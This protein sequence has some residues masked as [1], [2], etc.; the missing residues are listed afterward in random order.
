MGFLLDRINQK[1]EITNLQDFD[2]DSSFFKPFAILQEEQ[3]DKFVRGL[4][5]E[6]DSLYDQVY[7][8]T[9]EKSL[10]KNIKGSNMYKAKKGFEGYT[11]L[12]AFEALL[13][14]MFGWGNKRPCDFLDYGQGEFFDEN[15]FTVRYFKEKPLYERMHSRGKDGKYFREAGIAQI[16]YQSPIGNFIIKQNQVN[17]KIFEVY[18]SEDM[19]EMLYKVLTKALEIALE[20]ESQSIEKN[21][22][23]R[24]RVKIDNTRTAIALQEKTD[25]ITPGIED[26]GRNC[27]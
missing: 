20:M 25:T 5:K 9:G 19:S 23:E 8:K 22:S 27:K 7:E 11:Y 4:L 3:L 10:I 12:A 21:F 6:N 1:K 18:A 13:A 14:G 16:L 24:Y 2:T 26:L 15:G 17:D